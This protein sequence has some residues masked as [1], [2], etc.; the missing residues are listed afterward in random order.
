M[1][2]I[3]AMTQL[4]SVDPAAQI[5]VAYRGK[6]YKRNL[7]GM[8][9][10][11][12]QNRF[13]LPTFRNEFW[14][15]SSDLPAGP[16]SPGQYPWKYYAI[17]AGTLTQ[18]VSIANHPG[19][20]TMR[21]GAAA[22]TGMAFWMGYASDI[23]LQGEE[24]TEL[25]FSV[26]VGTNIASRFGFGDNFSAAAAPVDGVWIDIAV[27]T[28]SGKTRNNSVESTTGTTYLLTAGTWYRA[29]IVVNATATRVDFTLYSMAGAVL[30]TNFLTTNIPT[31]TGRETSHGLHSYKTAVTATNL[32]DLDFMSL[33]MP[34]LLVR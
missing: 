30:W 28:L 10:D 3:S 20:V 34:K 16:G 1:G 26:P 15:S 12:M 7:T 33:R 2:K 22:N 24:F 5:V 21:S 29:R 27:L 17:G 11:V 8:I 13:S 18:G 14:N 32:I 23:L 25:I 19:I 6:N 9:V 4:T 31:T